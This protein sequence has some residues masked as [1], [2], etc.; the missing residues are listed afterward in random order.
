MDLMSL[1]IDSKLKEKDGTHKTLVRV[2]LAE[3][4]TVPIWVTTTNFPFGSLTLAD[5]LAVI[6]MNND[7]EPIIW[8]VAPVSIIYFEGIIET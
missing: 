7:I 1:L 4:C 3:I 6:E 8:L 5:I 2:R